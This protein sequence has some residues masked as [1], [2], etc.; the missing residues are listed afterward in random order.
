G[1]FRDNVRTRPPS[2]H[3]VVLSSSSADTDIPT[4]PQVVPLVSSA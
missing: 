4:S 2:G 1:D 3:F